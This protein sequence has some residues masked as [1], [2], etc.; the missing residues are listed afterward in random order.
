M[1][2]RQASDAS[3]ILANA[4]RLISDAEHLHGEG[5]SR[6]AATLIVVALEQLGAFVEVLT[7]ETYPDATVHMGIF[8]E[9]ANAHAKRQDALAAHV[10]NYAFGNFM[11]K[12]SMDSFTQTRLEGEDFGAWL[13]RRGPYK[14]SEKEKLE[15]RRCPDIAVA[16]ILM[17]FVRSNRLKD[18]REFG[19]YENTGK[20][21]SDD[22]VRKAIGL[23]SRIRE[24]L[25]RSWVA[26]EVMQ[27]VGVN[28]PEGIQLKDL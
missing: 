16:H 27:L 5:R 8:G 19:L 21:F 20:E 13:I 2:S 18:L 9:K 22:E 1:T 12:T 11:M 23:T 6:S 26:P 24:I 7:K 4:E 17:H 15:E 28:M 3:E 25:S 14:L 10:M